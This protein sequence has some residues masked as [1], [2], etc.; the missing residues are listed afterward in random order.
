MR[1]GVRMGLVQFSDF[2]A[3]LA[4]GRLWRGRIELQLRPKSFEVLSFL[5]SNPGRVVTK[6]E[7][8]QAVWREV[9]VTDDSL[10]RCI[11][12]LDK[13]KLEGDEAV[14]AAIVRRA[15]EEPLRQIALNAGQEG[16]VVAEKVRQ[17]KDANYGF[18]AET[19]EYEDLVSAGVIDPT[20]VTRT[21]LQN[22]ASIAALLL[23]TEALVCEIK[24]EEK[25]PPTPPGGGGMY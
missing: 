8:L 13:M 11:S 22:A 4:G 20:K 14:G 25:T 10:I 19:E 7:I 6:D 18:N 17:S 1:L 12:A 16:A 5:L 3:D 2:A 24:E 9:F 23:T 21:A 15:L